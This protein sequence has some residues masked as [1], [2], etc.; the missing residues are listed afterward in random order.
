MRHGLLTLVIGVLVT[1]TSAVGCKSYEG[2]AVEIAWVIR[3]S[4]QHAYDCDS[5]ALGDRRIS[6]I[7][8]IIMGA[9]GAYEG[10]DICL[11]GQVSD[12]VFDCDSSFGSSTHRGIT[13]FTIPS[14]DW[15]IG[16]VPLDRDGNALLASEAQTP[17]PILQNIQT[18]DLTFLGVWQIVVN[19]QE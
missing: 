13:S 6:K 12:C 16:I 15:Y 2:G 9:S 10:Q 7:R 4:D 19:I 14:G 3:G 11:S 8:L 18:G 1:L 5:A 17:E